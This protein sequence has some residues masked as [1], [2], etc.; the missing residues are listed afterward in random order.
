M[1]AKELKT[2]KKKN[3]I[4]ESKTDYIYYAVCGF[5]LFLLAVI[6][7]YPLYYIVIASVSDPSAVVNG[8]VWLY[9]VKLTFSGYANLFNRPDVWRG[10]FNTLV[11]TLAGTAFNIV[12]TIPAGWALSRDYL[13]FRRVIMPLLIITMFFG[14]GLVPYIAVCTALGLYQNPLIM[15]LGGG[16]SVYNVFMCKSFFQTNVPKEVLE[17]AQIDG[18]GEVRTFFDIVLPLAKSIISVMVL[19]YAVGH[20]NNYIDALIFQ[21]DTDYW[22]LQTVLKA[23][24]EVSAG[25]GEVAAE[26]FLIAKQVQFTSIIIATVPILILYPMIEKHFGQGV[27]VGSFK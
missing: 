1:D 14:G 22:P 17:A 12:L 27:L 9:P 15:V 13:P 16:V 8:E 25:E 4:R 6:I 7:I 24:L 19:F 26:Q 18:A 5:I 11:Y 20:W 2:L 23:L 21:V 10:Y 3:K